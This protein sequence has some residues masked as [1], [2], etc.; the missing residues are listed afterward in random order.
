ML[1]NINIKLAIATTLALALVPSI[2][3]PKLS[4]QFGTRIDWTQAAVAKSN[5]ERSRDSF[6]SQENPSTSGIVLSN[7]SISSQLFYGDEG[8][9]FRPAKPRKYWLSGGNGLFA[10]CLGLGSLS[11]MALLAVANAL[12]SSESYSHRGEH[13]AIAYRQNLRD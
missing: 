12:Q 9:T 4:G 8:T 3:F 11:L 5:G 2:E 7:V 13:G 6:F 1:Q 10:M